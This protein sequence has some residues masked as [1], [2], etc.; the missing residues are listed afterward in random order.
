MKPSRSLIFFTVTALWAVACKQR[1]PEEK[2]ALPVEPPTPLRCYTELVV[3]EALGVW[4]AEIQV[5]FDPD[6]FDRPRTGATVPLKTSFRYD[7]TLDIDNAVYQ[8]DTNEIRVHEMRASAHACTRPTVRVVH[9]IAHR[10]DRWMRGSCGNDWARYRTTILPAFKRNSWL[11][12][13]TELGQTMRALLSFQT[14]FAVLRQFAEKSS[15]ACPLPVL[16]GLERGLSANWNR[17]VIATTRVPDMMYSAT[18]SEQSLRVERESLVT[19]I[20][21]FGGNVRELI[22]RCGADHEWQLTYIAPLQTQMV[23][24]MKAFGETV[25]K[26]IDMSLWESQD[27]LTARTLVATI[28]NLHDR[29]DLEAFEPTPEFLDRLQGCSVDGKTLFAAAVERYRTSR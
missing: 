6:S 26:S 28:L 5:L 10:V 1:V 16:A 18:V 14:Q 11:V 7:R 24:D 19:A 15:G 13:K 2:F 25:V 27:E 20:R 29:H 12:S 21:G 8:V 9:E 3:R 23:D 17:I 4:P 22:E